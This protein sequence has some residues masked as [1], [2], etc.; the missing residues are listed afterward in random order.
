MIF[1]SNVS[2]NITYELNEV[3]NGAKLYKKCKKLEQF[4]I[5]LTKDLGYTSVAEIIQKCM[6]CKKT[7]NSS[8]IH[9]KPTVK[10]VALNETLYG[11][12]SAIH[13]LYNYAA[14]CANNWMLSIDYD[15]NIT[16]EELKDMK[17]IN[18]PRTADTNCVDSQEK[19]SDEDS[20]ERDGS[21]LDIHDIEK[22]EAQRLEARMEQV[23]SG[24]DIIMDISK[25]HISEHRATPRARTPNKIFHPKPSSYPVQQHTNPVQHYASQYTPLTPKKQFPNQM[26]PTTAASIMQTPKISTPHQ[27]SAFNAISPVRQPVQAPNVLKKRLIPNVVN[28]SSNNVRRSYYGNWSYNCDVKVH[29]KRFD[30]NHIYEN[31][32]GGQNFATHHQ[33]P[34]N[35]YGSSNQLGGYSSKIPNQIALPSGQRN[36]GFYPDRPTNNHINTPSIM[37]GN[38]EFDVRNNMSSGY[39]VINK[40]VQNVDHLMKDKHMQH[41]RYFGEG[42]LDITANAV[43][44]NSYPQELRD[45]HVLNNARLSN[46]F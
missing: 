40:A 45:R 46:L 44:E 6:D 31:D 17:I 22:Q 35:M 30:I 15:D 9:S 19:Y 29:K 7:P 24:T 11:S 34:R 39:Q 13:D 28:L 42:G 1:I 20:N 41:K 3:I 43:P 33:I 10:H 37:L 16:C 25:M 8:K 12:N 21:L 5:F 38:R 18:E 23:H 14:F 32:F 27:I 26:F 36:D 2:T 4:I